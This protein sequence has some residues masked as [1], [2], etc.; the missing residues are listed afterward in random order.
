M[1]KLMLAG[2]LAAALG[3]FAV[4][5][6][7]RTN[8]DLV[9]NFGP[10]PVRYEVVPAP[11]YGYVWAPGH[12][13]WRGYRHFWVAGHW[14]RERHGYYYEPARWVVRDGGWV[15]YRGGWHRDRYY[16]YGGYGY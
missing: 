12:W 13:E 15:F 9:L 11:R 3:S 7:A 5:A 14:I 6:D 4:P 16:V 1:R 2:L 10:P 8:V